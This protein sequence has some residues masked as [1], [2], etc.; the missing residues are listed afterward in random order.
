MRFFTDDNAKEYMIA[1]LKDE[2]NLFQKIVSIEYKGTIK[3][4]DEKPYCRGCTIH[5]GQNCTP[6]EHYIDTFLIIT[7]CYNDSKI[8]LSD[9]QMGWS[10]GGD[11]CANAFS[12]YDNNNVC[13]QKYYE[14]DKLKSNTDT[15][16]TNILSPEKSNSD[17]IGESD[18]RHNNQPSCP[19]CWIDEN[20]SL[21]CLA[22]PV[23]DDI[24]FCS[25]N[26]IAPSG[27]ANCYGHKLTHNGWKTK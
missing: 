10:D 1:Y 7:S 18:A 6:P 17:P 4:R 9:L 25:R 21:R 13:H 15:V 26:G 24:T 2:K 23:E 12:N 3:G 11:N 19:C 27:D 14:E 8:R 20:G 5:D 22:D 16:N